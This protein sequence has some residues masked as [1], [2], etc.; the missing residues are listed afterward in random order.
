[1]GSNEIN[2]D[3]FENCVL[4]KIINTLISIFYPINIKSLTVQEQ[5]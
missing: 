4:K 2:I 5:L 3:F 1:M